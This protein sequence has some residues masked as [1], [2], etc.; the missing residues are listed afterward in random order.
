MTFVKNLSPEKYL[1]VLF[2]SQC[3]I[4]NSSSGIREGSYLGIPYVNIGNRQKNREKGKNV[5]D[6][7]Y[8]NKE[9]I[10]AIR[11]QLQKKRYKRET[12][13]GKGNSSKLISELLVRLPLTYEKV[14][15]YIK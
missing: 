12:I 3:F 10:K 11:T 2:N 1:K 14:L 7:G 15:N 8:S 13:Y 5:I 4:G 9:I 6:V